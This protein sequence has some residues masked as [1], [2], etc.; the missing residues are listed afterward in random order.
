MTQPY[1]PPRETGAGSRRLYRFGPERFLLMYGMSL[2]VCG[3]LLA[4]WA[5]FDLMSS[6]GPN[7]RSHASQFVFHDGLRRTST[8]SNATALV[9]ALVFW[10]AR[11]R[12]DRLIR[13]R[14]RILRQAL[15]AALPAYLV[16]SAI[17][18]LLGLA[19]LLGP[20]GQPITIVSL[21]AGIVT[22]WDFWI[23]VQST[24]LDALLIVTLAHLYLARW[25][26][27][28]LALPL[29]ILGALSVATAA[30]LWIASLIS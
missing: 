19:V 28:S 12:P 8:L 18:I 20:F 5:T 11:Q 13:R 15:V 30:H 1:A 17:A 24:A 6:A 9:L 3:G 7:L 23:G 29:K 25:N 4:C 27:L 26:S 14:G 22:H 2:L 16:S 10:A 21:G